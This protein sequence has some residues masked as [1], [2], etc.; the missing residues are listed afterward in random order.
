MPGSSKASELEYL[1]HEVLSSA[2]YRDICPDLIRMIG[3]Q[4]LEK[5]RTSKEAIKQTKNKLHQ[6]SG[7]YVQEKPERYEAWLG[8]LRE[9]VQAGERAAIEQMCQ[10]YM[11]YHASTKERLPI[12]STFYET[13]RDELAD[14]ESVLDVACGLNPLSIPWMGLRAGIRYYAYDIHLQMMAFL[15]DAM[16]L[17][18]VEGVAKVGD[19]IQQVPEEAVDVALVLKTIP[20]LEQVD[21]LAG[22]RLL[23]KIR[24][25]KLIASFPVYSLGGRSKGMAAFYEGH[26]RELVDGKRWE[27][28]K[29]EFATELVFVVGKENT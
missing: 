7:A 9:A 20:C 29:Y 27:I 14:A 24:A 26:F 2:K 23:E 22:K 17:L 13:L 12:L 10:Q 25:K 11:S 18:G 19:V 6:I 16:R 3:E 8:T 15:G 21:K 4:E 28:K 1:L 5:R